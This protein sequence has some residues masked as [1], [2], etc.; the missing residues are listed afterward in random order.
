MNKLTIGIIKEGKT[1]PDSRV[2]LTPEQC[3]QLL[4]Q[5]GNQIDLVVESSTSRCF[6][7]KEYTDA[8]IPVV[9]DVRHCD[10]LMGVK[11]VPTSQ[12]LPNKTYFFFSHTIKAQPHNQDLMR[13]L[14]DKD[15]EMMDYEC[16]TWEDNR[17]VLGF[18]HFAGIVGAH[19]T[20]LA[21]GKKTGLFD[22]PPAYQCKDFAEVKAVYQQLQLPA[23]K[24]ALTGKGRVS[25]GAKEVLDLLGIQEVSPTDYLANTYPHAVYVQLGSPDLYRRKDFQVYNRADYHHQP[26]LYESTFLPYTRVTDVMMNGVFWSANVPVFF[27]KEQMR[28]PDFEIKVIG[29]ISCD[30]E[31]SIPATLR[32]TH[33]GD[34]VFGYNPLTE[35]EE[36]PYQAH[37]IDIMAVDNLPNEL[38]RDA[39]AAFGAAFLQYV[40][41]ELLQQNS[42]MLERSTI[43]RDGQL[44]PRFD[45]L[46]DYAGLV[47]MA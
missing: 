30:V 3:R 35:Q 20:L 37:T 29:D 9:A 44:M 40:I 46:S 12:L 41:P 18:G 22:L 34:A 27:T 45:Y 8:G 47:E 23:I 16:L 1:P 6:T 15:I 2:P 24:I 11:E 43:C 26:E 42:G 31:G 33:I 13:A 21:Y 25:T 38:P 7:D 36:P 10:V 5:Y 14:L 19:N 4:D 28:E 32:S 39:S 17:R